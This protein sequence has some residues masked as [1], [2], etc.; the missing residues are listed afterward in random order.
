M[1]GTN[2]S[3]RLWIEMKIV[4]G[5]LVMCYVVGVA[6]AFD[7]SAKSATFPVGGAKEESGRATAEVEAYYGQMCKI[8]DQIKC[9]GN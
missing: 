7:D 2:G 4:L 1:V 9:R 5:V 8:C 3:S 6:S